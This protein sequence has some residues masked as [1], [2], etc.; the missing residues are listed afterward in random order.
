MDGGVSQ[1]VAGSSGGD[2][3]I[4]SRRGGGTPER[5]RGLHVHEGAGH[6]CGGNCHGGG[7]RRQDA[8][9]VCEIEQAQRPVLRTVYCLEIR[10][11]MQI[12]VSYYSRHL[13]LHLQWKLKHQ[14]FHC[15]YLPMFVLLVFNINIVSMYVRLIRQGSPSHGASALKAV[16]LND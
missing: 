11:K 15:S 8:E 5:R 14:P 6:V 12:F 7:L 3:G 1:V 2:G 10:G 13:L 9:R 16:R 4:V